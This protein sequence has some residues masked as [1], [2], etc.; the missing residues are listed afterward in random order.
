LSE[1]HFE[2]FRRMMDLMEFETLPLF[3]KPHFSW[4][5]HTQYVGRRFHYRP[6]TESTMDDARRMLE[7]WSFPSGTIVLAE[8][9]TAGRGRAGRS[10]VSP[11]DVNLHF[12]LVIYL[13]EHGARP[14]AYVTPL[15]IA[16]AVEQVVDRMGKQIQVDLKWPNDVLL[17]GKKIG[18]VLI[19]TTSS[20]EGQQIALIGAG[21]NVNL[22]PDGHPEIAD[23]ATSIKDVAGF[24]VP[25]EE[26]LAEFCDRFEELYERSKAGDREPFEAWK[27]RLITL[28][29]DVAARGAGSEIRGVAVDVKDDGTLVIETPDGERVNV[30]AGD[31][32][33]SG[34]ES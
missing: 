28:G 14:L 25:R 33:L 20:Q 7:R 1:S 17:R 15:A 2:R 22:D 4:N 29:A 24:E 31:V 34:S 18:G 19:E 3:S 9:Q 32:T 26:V 6:Y 16:E 27:S 13:D 8:S 5:L 10:W 11:P 12:T 21:I 30:E 23:I